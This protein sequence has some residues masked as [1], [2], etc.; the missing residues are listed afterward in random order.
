MVLFIFG[1]HADVAVSLGIGHFDLAH[2][3]HLTVN[4]HVFLKIM[5]A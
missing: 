3:I 5:L 1:H 4:P 2:V